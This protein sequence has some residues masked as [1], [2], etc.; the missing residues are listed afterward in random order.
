MR[1]KSTPVM[2][3]WSRPVMA[4]IASI[5]ASVTAYLTYTKL[6]GNQA[7]CPTGGCD[8]VLSS[9]YATIFGLPLPLFGFLAYLSMIVLAIAPLLVN[10][11]KHKKLRNKLEDYTGL[12]LFMG[13][14]AMLVF[15]GYL[16]YLLAF[17]IKAVC[18]YC[19]ASALFAA[20]LFIL[21]IAGREWQDIGQ[22]FF[23][24]M[25]VTIIVLVG[26]LGVYANANKPMT[27]SSGS[28][29]MPITTTAGTAEIELA[30][31]LTQTGAKFY[32]SFLCGHCHNQKQL[33]GKEA[34][35]SIPYIECTKPDKRTQTDI[36][37]EQKIQ[38]YP[39]W[40]IGDKS[41]TGTQPLAKLAELSG[42]RGVSNFKNVLPKDEH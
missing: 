29:G 33:F 15:S 6:T 38:G 31:H 11:T 26:T 23:N 42:Y 13:A 35:A 30:K 37:I 18:I 9:P 12:L 16:M 8:V 32:G 7:A 10:A 21:S 17:E 39:H 19:V 41:F 25:V 2:H 22:L 20:T 14:T 40:K 24:G 34:V 28:Q 4:G 27:A 3:R 36:C 5:G 1:K